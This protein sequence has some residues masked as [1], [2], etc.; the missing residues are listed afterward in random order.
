MEYSFGQPLTKLTTVELMKKQI[1]EDQHEINTLRK[2]V[3]ELR[4]ENDKLKR[5]LQITKHV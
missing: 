1:A 5:Q 3:V 2:R 4:E